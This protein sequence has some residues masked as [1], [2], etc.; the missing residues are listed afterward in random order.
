MGLGSTDKEGSYTDLGGEPWTQIVSPDKLKAK[1]NVCLKFQKKSI[2][3]HGSNKNCVGSLNKKI[4]KYAK[5][6]LSKSVRYR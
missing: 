2:F 6:H 5:F 3:M 4:Y 1:G